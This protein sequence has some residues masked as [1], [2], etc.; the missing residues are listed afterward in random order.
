MISVV[1]IST[2]R[3]VGVTRVGA[4]PHGKKPKKF[5]HSGKFFNLTKAFYTMWGA[6]STGVVFFPLWGPFSL[7][8]MCFPLIGGYWFWLAPPPLTKISADDRGCT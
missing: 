7:R 8:R 5:H 1:H 2:H 4:R 6:F 3:G